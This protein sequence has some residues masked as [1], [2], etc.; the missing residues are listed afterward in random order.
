MAG[1]IKQVS[2]HQLPIDIF[3]IVEQFAS[4]EEFPVCGYI[5][6]HYGNDKT[7]DE[8]LR[9]MLFHYVNFI[10]SHKIKKKQNQPYNYWHGMQSLAIGDG[11]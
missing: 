11:S 5:I 8:L 7:T 1:Y 2:V 6:G 3:T 4:L 10:C 9:Y